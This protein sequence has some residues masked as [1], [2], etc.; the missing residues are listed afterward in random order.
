M[1][2]LAPL[3][4]PS[5]AHATITVEPGVPI[6][7]LAGPTRFATA[8]RIATQTFPT[9]ATAV[10]ASGTSFADALSGN[11]LAGNL[12]API[13]L[14]DPTSLSPETL[15]ALL[16]MKTKSVM[17]LGGPNAVS[18]NVA[19]AIAALN[20]SNEAGGQIAV[21][22]IAGPS[23]YDTDKAVVELPP[24]GHIGKVNGQRTALLTSGVNFPDA[25]AGGAL[26][27]GAALPILLTDPATLAPQT[28]Q[29]LADLGIQHVLILGG[30]AAVG[31]SVENAVKAVG[32]NTDRLQGSTRT[33]TA[34]AIAEYAGL[35]LGWGTAAQA[36]E[37][38]TTVATFTHL[39][40]ARGDDASEGA[41]ALALGPHAGRQKA[42]ILLTQSVDDPSLDLLTVV[43]YSV[44]LAAP[45]SGLAGVDIA[46]GPGAVSDLLTSLIDFASG[47]GPTGDMNFTPAAASAS[48]PVM[49]NS[50]DPCPPAPAGTDAAV[51]VVLNPTG[52][53]GREIA[54]LTQRISLAGGAWSLRGTIPSDV[55]P[56]QY[57]TFAFCSFTFGSSDPVFY[58]YALLVGPVVAIS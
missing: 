32:V 23:R 9:A 15:S 20:S 29:A 41:D 42:P 47:G 44:E 58:S 39:N 34:A 36:P 4:A 56:G 33:A 6:T 12:G 10:V 31:A 22:R 24:V 43:G 2:V 7:R 27:Y 3:V 17:L 16:A 14:T 18:D 30:S 25:L 53:Q 5:V 55:V 46:G 57:G 37:S 35:T 49:A 52:A 8:A 38:S 21:T 26:A 54:V 51:E 40:V 1:V 45:G 11:Y 28:A 19:A 48:T 50:V 13:L